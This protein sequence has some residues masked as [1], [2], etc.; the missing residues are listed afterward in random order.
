MGTNFLAMQDYLKILSQHNY[1]ITLGQN[2]PKFF[3]KFYLIT[4]K[5]FLLNIKLSRRCCRANNSINN[6]GA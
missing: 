1:Y 3:G 4:A 5:G 6:E 2:L